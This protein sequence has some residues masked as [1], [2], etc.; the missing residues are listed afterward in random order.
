MVRDTTPDLLYAIRFSMSQGRERLEYPNSP[1]LWLCQRPSASRST[2]PGVSLSGTGCC[3][4]FLVNW[5]NHSGLFRNDPFTYFSTIDS[6]PLY[7]LKICFLVVY[8]SGTPTF[9]VPSPPHRMSL[10][11]RTTSDCDLSDVPGL[12]RL[13]KGV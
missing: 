1:F 10:V 6:Y 5:I 13:P 7:F 2:C 3:V 9:L 11:Y 8:V 12:V 4:R